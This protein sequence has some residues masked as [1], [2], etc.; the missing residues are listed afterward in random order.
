MGFVLRWV[1]AF[2][3]LTATF[4]PTQWNYVRWAR[5][6]W[7]EAMPIIVLVGLLLAVAYVLFATAVLRGIGVLGV[8]LI[9]AVFGAFIWVLVDYGWLNLDA[10]GTVT[11]VVIAG[12]SLILALGMYWGILWR[13]I[14]GQLEVDEDE[15]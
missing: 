1:A 5:E 2:V 8:L 14:S 10:P 13:R 4:N 9:L 3:L 11:W 12:L 6:N 7:A 15:G